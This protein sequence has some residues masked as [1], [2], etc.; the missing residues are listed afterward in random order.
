MLT[1]REEFSEKHADTFV[2]RKQQNQE[3]IVAEM[4]RATGFDWKKLALQVDRMTRKFDAWQSSNIL[5]SSD[6]G[7]QRGK[8]KNIYTFTRLAAFYQTSFTS[9]TSINT[10]CSR[11]LCVQ[12]SVCV[13]W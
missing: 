4:S 3:F 1:Q 11:W 5:G 9:L 7:R 13:R 2:Q 6:C 10:V 8:H 12:G